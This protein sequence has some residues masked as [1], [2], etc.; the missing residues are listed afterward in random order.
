METVL[1][2]LRAQMRTQLSRGTAPL[3][4]LALL[5]AAFKNILGEREALLLTKWAKL[6]EKRFV[7]AL[8]LH[9]KNLMEAQPDADIRPS[10][11]A[12]LMTWQQQLRKALLDELDTRMLPTLGL[13]EAFQSDTSDAP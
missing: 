5:D 8:R 13:L 11:Q 10:L 1:R 4:R 12:W 9:M 6:L 2:S 3:Q 7:Q